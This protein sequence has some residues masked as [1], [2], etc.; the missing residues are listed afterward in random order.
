MQIRWLQTFRAVVDEGG[1]EMAARAMNCTQSTVSFQI[2][3]L[4]ESGDCQV[5]FPRF[6]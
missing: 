4:E 6:A 5:I 3:R 2:K 1:F